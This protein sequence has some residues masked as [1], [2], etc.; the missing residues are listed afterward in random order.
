[1]NAC[2]KL[3]G[4]PLHWASESG[5][6]GIAEV[7]LEHEAS[8]I[9][10]DSHGLTPEDRAREEGQ[11]DLIML[12]N[13]A[14]GNRKSGMSDF[15][16]LSENNKMAEECVFPK[17]M[18]RTSRM[19]LADYLDGQTPTSEF[20]RLFSLSDSSYLSLGNCLARFFKKDK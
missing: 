18:H 20:L 1:V 9:I 13:A 8:T 11:N 15:M 7:L 12:L 6:R 17:R 19:V 2:S 5:H 3:Y 10:I 4:T 14:N 16:R